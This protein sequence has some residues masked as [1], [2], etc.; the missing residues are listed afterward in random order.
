MATVDGV[1]TN[2]E[3]RRQVLRQINHFKNVLKGYNPDSFTPSSLI[4]NKTLWM[5]KFWEKFNNLVDALTDIESD[6][7]TSQE[8]ID[9]VNRLMETMTCL[10]V[11]FIKRYEAKCDAAPQPAAG[12]VPGLQVPA[13]MAKAASPAY[14]AVSTVSEQALAKRAQNLVTVESEDVKEQINEAPAEFLKVTD[15]SGAE[16]HV[17]ELETLRVESLGPTSTW[18]RTP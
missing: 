9:D 7:D 3:V 6:P 5:S 12:L 18:R 15:W 14:S 17:V 16:D 2:S 8:S 13:P 1:A 4:R 10:S 11:D